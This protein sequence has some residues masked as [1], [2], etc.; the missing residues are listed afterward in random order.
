[1]SDDLESSLRSDIKYWL[2]YV[3]V[4][5]ID[6]TTDEDRHR[7][8]IVLQVRI[9]ENGANTNITILV[10]EQGNVSIV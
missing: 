5:S 6:V 2:P 8:N 9:T 1:V 3:I 7:I 10:S 4:D